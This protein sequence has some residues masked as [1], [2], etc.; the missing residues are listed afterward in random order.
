M[1]SSSQPGK[2]SLP[3]ASSGA[4]QPIPNQSQIGIE[5][6]RASFP[7]GFPPLTRTRLSAGGVPPFGTDMNG[8]L[9]S[10]TN[11]Q[12]WQSAGG[13]FSFDAAMA[14]AIGGY[15]KGCLLV[16]ADA[17]KYWQSTIDNNTSNPDTG[18]AGWVDPISAATPSLV[19]GVQAFARNSAPAGWITCNGSAVGRTDYPSLFAA[20][21]TT[22]GAG[23]GTTT[24]NVPDLRGEFVRGWDASRGVDPGRV[25]GS[26]QVDIFASHTHQQDVR[27]ILGVAGSAAQAGSA[28]GINGGTTQA[29]GG[30]ETRPRNIALLYCIKF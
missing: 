30:T 23:N 18:G 4:K 11:I 14:A 20:I 27:T 17:T 9:F 12:Q 15:P 19:G 5:D 21:G 28:N 29:T 7:D 25:F 26:F 8:I 13:L 16:S 3:F 6:G 1:Q 22:F 2:I 10:I 24:F